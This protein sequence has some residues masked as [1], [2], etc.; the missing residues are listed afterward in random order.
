MRSMRRKSMAF[1]ACAM[2]KGMGYIREIGWEKRGG[3]KREL[4]RG[5]R[6]WTDREWGLCQPSLLA[7]DSPQAEPALS[8]WWLGS[9]STLA[10]L[11]SGF[12]RDASFAVL[13]N[14]LLPLPN[15]LLLFFQG[16]TQLLQ[17]RSGGG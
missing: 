2:G 5:I 16:P 14:G 7:G 11:V 13:S 12:S 6:N 10:E 3:K 17:R 1:T 4:Q 8:M 9:P 15:V